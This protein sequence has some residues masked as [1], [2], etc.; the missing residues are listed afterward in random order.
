MFVALL[1]MTAGCGGDDGGDAAATT[2]AQTSDATTVAT[3][4]LTTTTSI[5]VSTTRSSRCLDFPLVGGPVNSSAETLLTNSDTGK[6]RVEG[7]ITKAAAVLSKETVP[8]DAPVGAQ[9]GKPIYFISINVGGRIVTLA[10]SDQD[11][12][13]RSNAIGLWSAVDAFSAQATA[14]PQGT[15]YLKAFLNTDGMQASRDCV[16]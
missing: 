1:V 10:H 5:G 9:R 6:R 7:E 15:S 3:T 2:D 13:G 14:F 16:A 4:A 8:N 12:T 11:N